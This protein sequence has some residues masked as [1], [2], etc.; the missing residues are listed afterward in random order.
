MR[1][2]VIEE[3][4]AEPIVR[5]FDEPAAQDGAVVVEV[6]AAGIGPTDIA[7][8]EGKWRPF[9]GQ[10]VVNGE[11]VGLVDG[12]RVYFGHSIPPYG[13]LAERTLVPEGWVWPIDDRIGDELGTAFGLAGS[14]AL[15]SLETARVD[16]GDRVLVLG[17]TGVV[18]QVG[19]QVARAMGAGVVAAAGRNTATL[20]RLRGEGLADLTATIG[21]GDDL[22]AL[23]AIS[24]DGWDVVLDII[25][26]PPGQAAL[27]TTAKGARIAV[28]GVFAGN[29]VTIAASDLHARTITSV[30]TNDL[31]HLERRQAYERL[32][33]LVPDAKVESVSFGLEQ[34]AEAWS[35]LRG[36]A[37]A[38][39]MI[40]PG[41]SG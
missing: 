14:A 25:F 6:I 22:A 26:G 37:N 34:V 24:G 39:V 20:D 2:A 8:A 5:D 11:G 13:G 1:A 18:G 15:V 19:L 38:K 28:M 31:T 21:Q 16:P 17:A 30:G 29:D 35:A 12:R 32:A 27:R 41:T 23:Q 4:G 36:S 33:A 3:Q 7:R 10:H 9:T 40:R